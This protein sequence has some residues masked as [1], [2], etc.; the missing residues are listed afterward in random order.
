MYD[1]PCAHLKFK[2]LDF[3]GDGEHNAAQE[4]EF[5][6]KLIYTPLGDR[7]SDP[8]PYSKE[9]LE[10]L[11]MHDL[12]MHEMH[13]QDHT[14]ADLESDWASS[15]DKM[16][17]SD[18]YSV[19]AAHDF[20]MVVFFADW[21]SH[22]RSFAPK[23]DEMSKEISDGKM[24][25]KTQNGQQAPVHFFKVNCVDFQEICQKEQI[26][27]YP[28]MRLYYQDKT[29]VDFSGVRSQSN[30]IKFLEN[31]VAKKKSVGHRALFNEG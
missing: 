3:F 25:F 29:Y 9:E 11:K 8:K 28:Q 2:M 30:V 21:C 27:G 24:K 18:F 16:K 6:G 13:V 10:Q 12:R 31:S 26:R 22:C 5:H 19:I 4:E 14:S 17:N 15:S 7:G 1:I 20:Q 23:W